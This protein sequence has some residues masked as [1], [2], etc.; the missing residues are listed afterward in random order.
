M[1]ELPITNGFYESMSL[2]ISAQECINWYP[3]VHE[4]PSL[5]KESLFGTPGITQLA[6]T[7]TKEQFNRGAHVKNGIPYFVNGDALYRL[8]SDFSV[9]SLGTISG[10]GRVW[11][12][13][14]GTQLII[15]VPGGSGYIFN[16]DA[17]VQF[18]QITDADFTANGNPQTVVFLD[19][20]F[21]LTT[22]EKKFIISALND[23]LSYDALDFGSAES[24]PDE[25]IAPALV[26]N[27]QLY[28][29]GGETTEGFQNIG[30]V[31]FPFQRNNV[32]SD[33]GCFAPFS[34]I[35]FNSTFYMIG[36]GTDESPAVW[37][38]AGSGYTK[39]STRPIEEELQRYSEAEI[40][41]AFAISYAQSG[42]YFIAF[43]VPGIDR[44]GRT[45]VFDLT[46]NR[47]HERRS[48]IEDSRWRV[49][50]LVTAYGKVIV[51][52]SIDGRIGELSL[53]VYKEYNDNIVRVVSTQPF[54]RGGMDLRV[55]RLELT[56]EAGVGDTDAADPQVSMSFSKDG[57]K[58]FS[59]ERNRP[60]GKKG[61]YEKRTIWRRNG[62][63]PRYAVF[64][65]RLSDPVKPVIIKLET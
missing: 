19:G 7:G 60:I 49:N 37:Q 23:G 1:A 65:F 64:R 22:D 4:A 34:A 51:A 33:R 17:G 24:D 61:E 13:D 30:G 28:I 6:T 35:S 14:N 12:A 63:F 62:R 47:W 15:L 40:Q 57:G 9:V 54:A 29:I 8:E 48:E 20:Y 10:S 52:D 26:K 53:D 45:F 32:F 36:G 27:S 5:S 39:V 43:T 42:S 50:S 46:T 56:M 3:V 38:W 18:Q 41:E 44:D 59:Y 31:G 11:M 2:P 25:I 16:E 58:T 55:P 21:V